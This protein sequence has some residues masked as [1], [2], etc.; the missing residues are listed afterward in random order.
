[1]TASGALLSEILSITDVSA[2]A[3][4]Y[5]DLAEMQSVFKFQTDSADFT[6]LSATDV[7][8]YVDSAHWP[9]LNPAD[10]MMD[11]AASQNPILTADKNGA[12]ASNKMMVAHDFIRYL[13]KKLF[14]TPYG[15]DLFSN[16]VA[17]LQNLRSVCGSGATGDAWFDVTEKVSGVSVSGSDAR[18]EGTAGSKYLTNG[19]TD[20]TNICREILLQ[21]AGS[22]PSRLATLV[23]TYGV[24]SV[25]FDP[26]D[27]I[28]FKLD[29]HAAAGQEGLTG[30]APIPSRPYEIKLIMVSDITG[31]NT[32]EAADE[33]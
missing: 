10:A 26:E 8:Y 18:L 5:V 32:E 17:L 2:T 3:I 12:L 30:V 19:V 25:P 4:L 24:Q 21:I 31:K 20:E 27:S 28:S 7:Q 29:I 13:A 1:M 9:S 16:E 11:D 14:N 23:N 33:Q 15:V 6:D 22:A